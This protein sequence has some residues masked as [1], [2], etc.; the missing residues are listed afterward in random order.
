M[1]TRVAF[2]LDDSPALP[3]RNAVAKF[4]PCDSATSVNQDPLVSVVIPCYNGEAFL[5][6]AIES[7][8][9]QSYQRVEIIVVDDGSTDSSAEV[10]QRFPVRYVYQENR[11][12]P[13]FA[14]VKAVMLP[15]STRMT[16]SRLMRS[17]PA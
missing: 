9:A 16:I 14:R 3:M 1:T 17:R 10:A 2:D 6:E 5:Q 4:T 7:A 11:A 12:I 13:A 8:L 15:S